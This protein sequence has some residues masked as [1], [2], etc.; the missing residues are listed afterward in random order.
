MTPDDTVGVRPC[1]TSTPSRGHRLDEVDVE[2]LDAAYRAAVASA[3][4]DRLPVIG[5]GQ[6]SVVFAWPPASPT[7]AVK[8]L[9][10]FV[11]S[12]RLD[13]Y[14]ALLD[15]YVTALSGRGLDVVPTAVRSVGPDD[16]RPRAY[17][18]QPLL[19]Q[20]SL[21]VNVLADSA[22]VRAASILEEVTRR[23]GDIADE[24][25]GI[26]CQVSNWA[27]EGD[28]L[29]YFDVTTPMLRDAAGRDRLDTDLFIASLPWCTRGAVR[30]LVAPRLL[31]PY[32]EPRGALLDLAGNLYRDH[33]GHF[34]PLVVEV[35]NGAV[36]PPLTVPEV[37]RFARANAAT[38]ESLQ[39]LRRMDRAWQMK[40]RSRTYEHL[41][42]R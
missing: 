19:D 6:V 11:S 32:H 38:W 13:R 18:L 23:V 9:P 29:R 10:P 22:P 17:V 20:S 16:D 2:G 3:R 28:R 24:H 40:V 34:V 12:D 21:L 14:V 36:S 15:E 26:D 5:F 37:R 4:A 42:P 7:V 8:S 30:R 35:V 25:L 41:L 39:W 33:L 31:D 27:L 1:R